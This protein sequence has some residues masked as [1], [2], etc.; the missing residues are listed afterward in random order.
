MVPEGDIYRILVE[1][2][3]F[4]SPSTMM[5]RSVLD[6]LGGYDENLSYEDFDFWVRS[7]RNYNYSFT[8]K[9]LVRKKVLSNSLS[10]LQYQRTNRHCLSTAIVC[11]KILKLNK[12]AEEKQAL[13]KRINYEL[14]WALITENWEASQK[15]IELKKKLLK[16][17]VSYRLLNLIVRIK[18]PWYPLWRIIF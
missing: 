10:S 16:S 6:E 13:L 9:V 4:S 7:S 2:Y 17:Y 8:D 5:R 11:E 3:F 1:R 14:K 12:T 15:F 18:P